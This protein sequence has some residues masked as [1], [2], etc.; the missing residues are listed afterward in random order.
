MSAVWLHVG[1]C[2]NQIGEERWQILTSENVP[3]AEA[4]R[5][6]FCTPDGK[7]RAICVD[8]E[9]KV[10]RKLQK[11]VK[12][13]SFRETNLIVGKRGRGN[14]W[15]YGY[16]G[17]HSASEK[18]L[19]ERTMDL[20]K[21]VERRDCYCGTVFFHSLS[22]GTGSG[23]SSRLCEAI[24]DE[25]SL[26]QILSVTVAPH[27]AGESLLQHY[28][29]LLCLVWL[30]RYG[31][32]GCGSWAVT[33]GQQQIVVLQRCHAKKKAPVS[34]LQPQVSLSAMNTYVASCLAGL[35]YPLRAF[36]TGRAVQYSPSEDLKAKAE[37]MYKTNA[38]LHWYW[39]YGCQ[40]EDF[41]QA[42]EMLCSVADDYRR[43]GK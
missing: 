2:G 35:L 21:E 3:H 27:Q 14:N 41:Q 20:R 12:R 11:R 28:N 16:H 39:R 5:Y 42:V 15:A 19:L 33:I 9:P 36:T 26:G 23:L 24:R 40:E 6:P 43:L 4:D 38:Y 17:L 7:L 30:Q 32:G 22:G 34:D 29:S 31:P 10:V 37:A 25:H 13:G 8:S 1:Q 18:N